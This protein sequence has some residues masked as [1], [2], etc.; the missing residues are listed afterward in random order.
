MTSSVSPYSSCN[1]TSIR[2]QSLLHGQTNQCQYCNSVRLATCFWSKGLILNAAGVLQSHTVSGDKYVTLRVEIL[3]LF[4]PS[5]ASHS[6][7]YWYIHQVQVTC[8][9]KQLRSTYGLAD[10]AELNIFDKVLSIGSSTTY[11]IK[12]PFN[13]F[14]KSMACISGET[15]I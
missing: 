5:V 4:F 15:V 11:S 7:S 3:S 8:L 13:N 1:K 14:L 9:M 2:Q 12:L 10:I 6:Y